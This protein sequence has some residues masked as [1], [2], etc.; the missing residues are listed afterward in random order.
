MHGAER[1]AK[2]FFLSDRQIFLS[3]TRQQA[4]VFVTKMDTGVPA[5][6]PG[7]DGAETR[8]MAGDNRGQ[9]RHHHKD[10]RDEK[11]IIFPR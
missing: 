1:I 4:L 10:G 8:V 2:P 11:G 9:L 3:R 6:L 5:G 7:R